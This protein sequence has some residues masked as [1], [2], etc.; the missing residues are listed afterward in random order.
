MLLVY[1]VMEGNYKKIYEKVRGSDG[2]YGQAKLI[3]TSDSGAI[4][5]EK[6]LLRNGNTVKLLYY[7][8]LTNCF[9][10]KD[11]SASGQWGTTNTIAEITNP[12]APFEFLHDGTLLCVYPKASSPYNLVERV[13]GTSGVWG[14]ETNINSAN[15]DCPRLKKMPDSTIICVY[16]DRSL[17]TEKGRMIKRSTNGTWTT[18]QEIITESIFQNDIYID[19]LF[20]VLGVIYKYNGSPDIIK[21]IVNSSYYLFN[22]PIGKYPVDLGAGI[23]EEGSNTNGSYIKFSNGTMICSF[24]GVVYNTTVTPNKYTNYG[25]G[26]VH[27]VLL[28]NGLLGS[29]INYP[30]SFL[31]GTKPIIT[32]QVH[33]DA[34]GGFWW[35]QYGESNYTSTS[36]S[37]GFLWTFS[38]TDINPNILIY[39]TAIGKWK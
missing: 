13:R 8:T 31:P 11:R 24:V 9:R 7:Y 3:E 33:A 38:P 18:Y 10:E 32:C 23:V 21:E 16:R 34:N 25:P 5:G 39:M 12:T 19:N 14:A 29:T 35:G 26:Y 17:G 22:I 4:F 15:S 37:P 20:G 27:S 36:W 30:A 28:N 6:Y 2:T 1:D